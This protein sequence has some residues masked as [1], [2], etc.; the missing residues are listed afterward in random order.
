MHSPVETICLGDV[1]HAARLVAA[2]IAGLKADDTF[3]V[4]R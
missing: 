4:I 2:F 3:R 1:R